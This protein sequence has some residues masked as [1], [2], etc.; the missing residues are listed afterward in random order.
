MNLGGARRHLG[1]ALLTVGVLSTA[2]LS[3][4]TD[5]DTPPSPS[6]TATAKATSPGA[7]QS[8]ASPIASP[9]PTPP[10]APKAKPTRKNAEA[11]VKYFW[12]VY[13]Y[14]YAT[15]DT[16]LLGDLSGPNCAFCKDT[17]KAIKKLGNDDRSIQGSRI[18]LGVAAAPPTDPKVGLVIATTIS[19]SPGRTI[20]TDGSVVS[21]TKGVRDMKS[22]MAIDWTGDRWLVRDLANDERTGRPW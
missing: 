8:P 12:D 4:C 21:R 22:E 1:A 2:G 19:E 15:L 6:I 18:E 20:D 16:H 3:A 17:I 10:T 7:S 13:N 5:D 14:S 11:F 9:A